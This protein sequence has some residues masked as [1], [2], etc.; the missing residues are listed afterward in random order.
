LDCLVDVLI[1]HAIS[2]PPGEF[3]GTAVAALFCN[4]LDPA[5]H[6]YYREIHALKVSAHFLI[7]RD[8]EIVQ[9]VPVTKRA[10]HAGKSTCLGRTRVNDFSIGIELEGCDQVPFDEPQYA[11]LVDLT[12]SLFQVFPGLN[13]ERIFGHSDI[14]PGRKTDPGPCFDWPRYKAALGG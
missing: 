10:W 5:A 3:G 1:V 12:R 4:R 13:P 9:F 2:L 7:H 8:G 6:S 11:S 14:A